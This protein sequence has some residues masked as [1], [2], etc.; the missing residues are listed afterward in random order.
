MRL[1]RGRAGLGR[2][3]VP[4]RVDVPPGRA[5]RATTAGAPGGPAKASKR[6]PPLRA[7][8]PGVNGGRAGAAPSTARDGSGSQ[9]VA[10]W[11]SAG[12]HGDQRVPGAAAATRT[13]RA[14][15]VSSAAATAADVASQAG[16]RARSTA[17]GRAASG[18][19]PP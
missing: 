17:L 12:G 1:A 6:R 7:A 10:W 15:N 11:G 19:E 14:T 4:Y 3:G 8:V 5:G 2:E 13:T 16:A 18:N 9:S